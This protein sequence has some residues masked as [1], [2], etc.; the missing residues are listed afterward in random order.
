[1]AKETVPKMPA[2][3]IAEKLEAELERLK[4]LLKQGY[5]L[6]VMW[7]PKRD[8]KLAGE[9]REHYIYVFD[10][11][12]RAALE[13][14]RHEVLDYMV[15]QAIE[16][17]KNITNHLIAVINREAYEKKESLIKSLCRLI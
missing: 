7:T 15:S 13:T 17:Y 1:M 16:P 3:G 2:K 5:E 4:S 6:R 9:V 11:E 12:E 14:L 10:E 8:S